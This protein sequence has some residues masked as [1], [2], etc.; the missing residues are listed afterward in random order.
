[1]L[2]LAFIA[3]TALFFL[4]GFGYIALCERLMK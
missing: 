3:L 1:V 4:A 2:D